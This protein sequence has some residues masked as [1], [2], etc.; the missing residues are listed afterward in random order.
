MKKQKTIIEIPA[1]TTVELKNNKKERVCAYCRVSTD[2]DEQ[3]HSY[4][5]QVDHYTDLIIRNPEW[6]FV[7]IYADKGISGKD[8]KHRPEFLRMISDCEYGKID[9]IITKSISRFARNTHDSIDYVR[10]LKNLGVAVYFE[11]ENLNTFDNTAAL[12]F[13]ILSSVAEEESRSISNNV[14]LT[15]RH[16]EKAGTVYVAPCYGYKHNKAREL[17]I[18]KKTMPIIQYIFDNFIKGESYV[19]TASDL[20]AKKVLTPGGENIKWYASTILDI[21]RNEKYIGDVYFQKTFTH[22]FLDKRKKNTGQVKQ[23]QYRDAHP[24]IISREQF[25]LAQSILAKPRPQPKK[26]N[27]IKY[28]F[29]GLIECAKCGRNYFMAASYYNGGRTLRYLC[30]TRKWEKTCDAPIIH[31]NAILELY[32]SID[33]SFNKENIREHVQKIFAYKKYVIFNLK[34]GEK[35]KKNLPPQVKRGRKKA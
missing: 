12:I 32:M 1:K 18:D 13:N 9:R 35:V 17:V 22:D 23:L 28:L 30:H 31:E 11:K 19:K 16:K 15:L 8:A 24:A 2:S 7:R 29:S 4:E 3:E 25:Y 5:H 21:L 33:K 26:K 14:K 10:Q 6:E 34:N 20:T 27:S